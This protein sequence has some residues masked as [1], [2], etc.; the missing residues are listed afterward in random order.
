MLSLLIARTLQGAAAALLVP[1][2]LAT[3][4][5]GLRG[6]A[7]SRALALFASIGGIA[8]IIGQVL[9]GLLVDADI[10]GLGWRN[11]FLINL[12]I[13]LA[14]LV[15]SPRV[16]PETRRENA[17]GID[18]PGTVLLAAVILAILLPIALGPMFRWSWPVLAVLAA[19]APLMLLLWHVELRR[20][21]A[22]CIRYC[23]HR[24]CDCPACASALSSP[25][26]SMRAGAA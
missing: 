3:I 23:H 18:A 7:H 24:C 25:Y 8:F 19:T 11:A 12:P 20:N 1:Q 14:I 26:S 4:H 15:L 10:G 16:I 5:V 22:A 9:G 2:I 6:H 21:A 17:T 13:C